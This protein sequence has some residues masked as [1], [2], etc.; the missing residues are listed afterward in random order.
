MRPSLAFRAGVSRLILPVII[1]LATAATTVAQPPAAPA[2]PPTTAEILTETRILQRVT[3]AVDRALAYQAAKQQPDGAWSQNQAIN[4]LTLLSYLG[5][6]HVPGRGPYR[7]LLARG[8]TFILASQQKT[9]LF[10]SPQ[11]SQ[12]PMYEHALSTLAC[13][14]MYGMDPDPDLEEKL[15]KAVELIVRAAEP[16]RRL[17]RT[18]PSRAIR[19]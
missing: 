8:K 4:A 3:A 17:A 7:D 18:S 12:G 9:G 13:A 19:I 10:L 1:L 14:E 2:T 11:P 6:G 5:R 15:R 16:Q